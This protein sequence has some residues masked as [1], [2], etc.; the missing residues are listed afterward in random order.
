MS[1]QSKITMMTAT[2]A[3]ALLALSGC[4]MIGGGGD[5]DKKDE[6]SSS[7]SA[8][9][10]SSQSET[11]SASP[12]VSAEE[13]ES[14]AAQ[15][16][17]DLTEK[18]LVAALNGGSID[19]TEVKAATQAE[20]KE[21]GFDI[22]KDLE[23]EMGGEI[24]VKPEKCASPVRSAFLGNITEAQK[25]DFVVA[26]DG[27]GSVVVTAKTFDSPEEAQSELDDFTKAF[28]DCNNST[29]SIADESIKV[30]TSSEDIKVD[31]AE[32]AVVTKITANESGEEI[33]IPAARMVY[34]NT[35]VTLLLEGAFE[36]ND[37]PD[38]E[39]A[40]NEVADLL[41]EES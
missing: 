34:G 9:S 2:S 4:T 22:A 32:S 38:Y 36:G 31:G 6:K 35:Y 27:A 19:G 8:S 20:I 24:Q 3:A 41:A 28:D 17:D 7:A 13:S 26:A 10:S 18:Q 33:D 12:S 23:E 40:L 21:N 30:K 14:S 15:A 29:M 25:D 37:D 16:P 11:S 5:D 39:S 1:R